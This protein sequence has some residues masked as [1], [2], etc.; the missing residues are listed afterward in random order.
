[1]NHR[2]YPAW[3]NASVSLA[4]AIVVCAGILFVYCVETNS[5]SLF[6][7]HPKSEPVIK[8]CYEGNFGNDCGWE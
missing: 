2:C 7:P 4:S 5:W 6:A 3:V 1:M 8:F